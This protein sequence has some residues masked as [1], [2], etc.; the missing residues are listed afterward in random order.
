M[1]QLKLFPKKVD[2]NPAS[3]E[4]II[5]LKDVTSLNGV[6]VKI[7]TSKEYTIKVSLKNGN[8]LVLKLC[9]YG[10]Y[11]FNISNINKDVIFDS[12]LKTVNQN[13]THSKH[14]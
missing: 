2:Y 9:S 4:N 1:A 6:T 11:H 10:Y 12:C 5:S 3:L 14:R 13:K 7:Y 8:T